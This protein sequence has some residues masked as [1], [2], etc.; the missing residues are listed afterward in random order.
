MYRCENYPCDSK[1]FR[2]YISE[3]M[4]DFMLC[5]FGEINKEGQFE[6]IDRVIDFMERTKHLNRLV[7]KEVKTN[8]GVLG[9]KMLWEEFIKLRYEDIYMKLIDKKNEYTFDELGEGLIYLLFDFYNNG[10]ID[11]LFDY[12]D[13]SSRFDIVKDEDPVIIEGR[14]MKYYPLTEEMPDEINGYT[15]S[16]SYIPFHERQ[17]KEERSLLRKTLVECADGYYED[18]ILEVYSEDGDVI[19]DSKNFGKMYSEY[20]DL[21]LN[22]ISCYSYDADN[23][24]LYRNIVN[25]KYNSSSDTK[26]YFASN[27]LYWDDDFEFVL[28]S[29]NNK[30]YLDTLVK[31]AGIMLG[32]NLGAANDIFQFS[33]NCYPLEK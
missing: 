14:L 3:E 28:A 29:L 20:W 13:N 5:V 24:E 7:G 23:V 19:P 16:V 33:D 9:R 11:Y 12:I 1:I 21:V 25:A 15:M 2:K 31:T 17:N 30:R 27:F 10:E 18:V 4:T 26:I 22:D 6:N 32:Y 8:D